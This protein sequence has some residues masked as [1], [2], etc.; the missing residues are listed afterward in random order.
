MSRKR[1]ASQLIEKGSATV[2]S[3]FLKWR[4]SVVEKTLD[5]RAM[6]EQAFSEANSF[7][8]ESSRSKPELVA[9]LKQEKK[10]LMTEKV[11]LL[12]QRKF[13]EEDLND[14]DTSKT[15]LA[16]AYINE[17]R[18]SLEKC[19]VSRRKCESS[20]LQGWTGGVLQRLLTTTL[21]P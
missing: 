8:Q 19:P 17:L 12:S 13:L 7:F 10:A 6:Q 11:Y 2:T 9:R 18:T 14:I 15:G 5:L 21:A 4:L 16:D 20:R 1:K 3:A